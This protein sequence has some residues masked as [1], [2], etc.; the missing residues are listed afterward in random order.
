MHGLHWGNCCRHKSQCL[1]QHNGTFSCRV[2]MNVNAVKESSAIVSN[3]LVTRKKKTHWCQD[4]CTRIQSCSSQ[5][6]LSSGSEVSPQ[7]F[8]S[9][10]HRCGKGSS[11]F[12]D[13][14][15]NVRAKN[16]PCS[17]MTHS[18][19]GEIGNLIFRGEDLLL[20][21]HGQPYQT[22]GKGNK[23]DARTIT[24]QPGMVTAS[25]DGHFGTAARGF[26]LPRLF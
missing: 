13:K 2:K 5:K 6:E 9:P 3:L 20:G 16:F 18:A 25:H 4:R 14:Q 19:E 7:R 17:G 21:D 15:I 23:R 1:A 11:R 10:S 8:G 22:L 26:S 24:W 12:W